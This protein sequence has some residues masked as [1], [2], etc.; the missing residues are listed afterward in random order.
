MKLSLE[1]VASTRADH[2]NAKQELLDAVIPVQAPRYMLW[3][4]SAGLS[5]FEDLFHGFGG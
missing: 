5:Q 4:K 1:L 2:K 3:T